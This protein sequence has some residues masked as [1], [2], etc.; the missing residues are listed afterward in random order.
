MGIN[1]INTKIIGHRLSPDMPKSSATERIPIVSTQVNTAAIKQGKKDTTTA[2]IRTSETNIKQ[3]QLTEK[4]SKPNTTISKATNPTNK[5][6][7]KHGSI[8]QS[9]DNSNRQQVVAAHDK[10][11][12]ILIVSG[13]LGGLDFM[14]FYKH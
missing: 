3:Q 12:T 2:A 7:D 6:V 4:M 5:T 9:S 8:Y 10:M 11:K 1:D 13:V 14:Y